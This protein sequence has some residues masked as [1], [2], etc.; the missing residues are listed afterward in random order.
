[1]K[2]DQRDPQLLGERLLEKRKTLKRSKLSKVADVVDLEVEDFAGT[3][4]TELLQEDES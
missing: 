1:M 3:L 2:R 4:M